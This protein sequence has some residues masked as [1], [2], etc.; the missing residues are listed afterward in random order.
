MNELF[1]SAI[2]F[3]MSSIEF[4]E[5]EPQ[6]YWA[7]RFSY[8]KKL[9]MEQ[10]LET[11]KMQRSCWLQGAM[12]KVAYEVALNNAFSKS[13]VEYPSYENMFK[14]VKYKNSKVYKDLEKKLE[15]V[16]EPN[17]RQQIEFNYWARI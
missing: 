9:E 2:M 13:K 14:E 6:L 11:E 5:D 15:N 17:I 16:D 10:Q 12:N 4:W 3:G 7:Y 1:P 8:I